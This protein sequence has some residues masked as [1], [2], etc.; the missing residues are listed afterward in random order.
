MSDV[1][2][3]VM[4][5]VF[6]KVDPTTKLP[7]LWQDMI[8]LPS[9]TVSANDSEIASLVAFGIIKAAN[10]Y[11]TATISLYSPVDG[12]S[13]ETFHYLGKRVTEWQWEELKANS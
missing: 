10:Q 7:D 4:A 3:C 8:P 12:R 6:P 5:N 9:F 11:A 2:W 13:G 1:R